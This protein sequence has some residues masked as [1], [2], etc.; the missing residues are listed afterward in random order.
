M[1]IVQ[2]YG[3]SPEDAKLMIVDNDYTR[4]LYTKTFTGTEWY[5]ARNYDVAIN[6]ARFGVN[7]AVN[8]LLELIDPTVK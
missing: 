6:M 8:Y 1:R 2:K 4:E 5:D 7:G 3:V